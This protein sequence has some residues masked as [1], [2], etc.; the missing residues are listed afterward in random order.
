MSPPP[1][2]PL[3]PSLSLSLSLSLYLSP[4]SFLYILN[5]PAGYVMLCPGWMMSVLVNPLLKL[6]GDCMTEVRALVGDVGVNTSHAKLCQCAA[7]YPHA[8]L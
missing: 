3:P 7:L 1:S 6:E 5:S 4:S 8:E 2:Q